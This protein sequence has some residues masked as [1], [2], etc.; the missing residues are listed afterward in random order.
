MSCLS[1]IVHIKA[2]ASK[3]KV[4]LPVA[5]ANTLASCAYASTH[6]TV[7]KVLCMSTHASTKTE[8]TTSAA[9]CVQSKAKCVVRTIDPS[10]AS[11]TMRITTATLAIKPA[12]T[13]RAYATKSSAKGYAHI[14][15]S[16]TCTINAT[17]ADIYY[18]CPI[19]RVSSC[20]GAG[21]W[22]EDMPWREDD[23]WRE[24]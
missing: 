18:V 21:Y 14:S 16:A 12:T 3:A 19:D 7:A 15:T 13:A 20:F 24:G 4:V 10:R 1:V 17:T 8:F 11:C 2:T 23:S 9:S 22:I 5:V 6:A